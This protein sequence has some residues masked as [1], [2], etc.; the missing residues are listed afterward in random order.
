MN[1]LRYI[2]YDRKSTEAKERQAL[3]IPEQKEENRKYREKLGLNVIAELQEEKSAF[4]P[5]NRPEF[6]KMTRMIKEDKADGILTWKPDRLCRN[7]EEGGKLLQML[8]NGVIKEIRTPLGDIYTPDSDQLILLIHFGMA[9]QYSRN[10]SQNVKRAMPYKVARGEYF[11]V[12]PIGYENYGEIRGHRN[13]SPDAFA[14]P[15]IKD[16]FLLASKGHYSIGYIANYLTEKGLKT[17]KGKPIGKSHTRSILSR[18]VYYG[19]FM[20][21]GELYKGDYAPIISKKLFDDVQ[22]ALGNRSVA[23]TNSWKH[24]FNGLLHCAECGCSITTSVKRKYYKKTNRVA[25]YAYHHC[26]KRRGVCSQKPI[27]TPKLQEILIGEISKIDIDV[28]AWTL[29]MELIKAKHS[30][31]VNQNEVQLEH[32]RSEYNRL[33]DRLNRLVTMRA[34]GE[35]TSEEFKQQKNTLLT[36]RAKVEGRISDTKFSSDNWLERAEEFL[37]TAYGAREVIGGND[38]LKKRRLIVNVCSNLLYKDGN[39]AI[40]YRKPFDMLLDPTY[41][42][43]WQGRKES[44]LRRRFWRPQSYH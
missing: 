9:N 15:L 11:G 29:G 44:D 19:Y 27:S 30:S 26:T 31:Q 14:A 10:I 6:D 8:Q 3:S 20:F 12:A 1:N 42:T 25:L 34:D 32:H 22:L 13:I 24:P 23:K 17:S 37:D 4:K 18:P 40:T 28:E 35:L 5:N 36:E 39:V 33:E 21:K 38:I 43:N 2:Q 7:P 41:R 16:A